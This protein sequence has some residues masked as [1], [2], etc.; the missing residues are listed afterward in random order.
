VLQGRRLQE[1][2]RPH[3]EQAP[4]DTE[5]DPVADRFRRLLTTG[6]CV[7]RVGLLQRYSVRACQERQSEQQNHDDQ[8]QAE[9][10]AVRVTM[11][12]T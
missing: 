7:R 4:A 11:R 5:G 12:L 6:L 3:T 10:L 8:V 1:G 9:Q 2:F